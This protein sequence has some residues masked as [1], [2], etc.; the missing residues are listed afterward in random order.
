[1]IVASQRTILGVMQTKQTCPTCQGS[2]EVPKKV[3]STCRGSGLERKREHLSIEIP[4]GVD[5]GAMLRV[6]GKGEAIRA[7]S[8][9]DLFVQLHVKPDAQFERDGIH[10][11][12]QST[13]GFT[14]AA[15]G[16]TIEVKTV[17]GTVDLK[18]PA[19]TQS[20]SLFR[21]RGKG[22]PSARGRGDQLVTIG[23]KTPERLSREQK[24]L[25][26]KLDL[27]D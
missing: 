9:G 26:E 13:I 15:L 19:G 20:G 1:M 25:L 4:A 2:G 6:K 11:L 7:G 16:D 14:Q 12:S 24:K 23:V 3:C 17:D 21:L 5:N 8:A 22:V 18:I 27:K 10:I